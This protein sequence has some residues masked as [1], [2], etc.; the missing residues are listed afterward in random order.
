MPIATRKSNRALIRVTNATETVTLAQLSAGQPAVDSA[1]IVKIFWTGAVTIARGATTLFTSA[2][3][4]QGAWDLG[5][6]AI[7]LTEGSN[8]NIAITATGS[9]A[10]IEVATYPSQAV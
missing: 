4:T 1:V 6:H 10:L 7:P 9:T 3:G 2:A 5:S 8:Q